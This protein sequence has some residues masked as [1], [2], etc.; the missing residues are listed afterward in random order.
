MH[1]IQIYT[2][3]LVANFT[4]LY[5]NI[6]LSYWNSIDNSIWLFFIL[7]FIYYPSFN[8]GIPCMYFND[9][10]FHIGMTSSISVWLFLPGMSRDHEMCFSWETDILSVSQEK[11]LSWSHSKI[12]G[13]SM[14]YVAILSV[15]QE[16]HLSWFHNKIYGQSMP[17]VAA[18]HSCG[19]GC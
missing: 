15:S 13:K 16:K 19:P 1:L 7:E 14:P 5:A 9:D 12:Y 4:R 2:T 8:I 10:H 3:M 11:H 18:D 17:H 6:L